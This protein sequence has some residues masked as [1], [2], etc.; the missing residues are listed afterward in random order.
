MDLP[1]QEIVGVELIADQNGDEVC[2]VECP[3]PMG[4]A[5]TDIVSYPLEFFAEMWPSTARD[6]IDRV[7]G[8]KL[9]E[10]G[11]ARGLSG[12]AGNVLIDG[13]HPASKTDSLGDILGRI[14][15]GQVARID[16]IRGGAP[17][18]D[19]QG[20]SVVA[21]VVRKGGDTLAGVMD[22]AS[23]IVPATD[24]K[25]IS[26]DANVTRRSGSSLFEGSVEFDLGDGGDHAFTDRQKGLD[27][28]VP[29]IKSRIAR[30]RENRELSVSAAYERPLLNGTVRVNGNFYD[31]HHSGTEFENFERP[32]PDQF[33]E[34]SDVNTPQGGEVGA[35]YSVALGEG[36]N[37]D[38]VFLHQ[39]RNKTE[40]VTS[41]NGGDNSVFTKDEATKETVA[42]LTMSMQ[43]L[44]N[45]SLE[46]GFEG[47]Y[48]VLKGKSSLL[49]NGV[50]VEVPGA[51]AIVEEARG[52]LSAVL[53]WQL[54]DTLSLQSALRYEASS[55][56]APL[57]KTNLQFA[58]PSLLLSWSPA[59]LTQIRL[60]AA[61]EVGQLNFND[62]LFSASLSTGIVTAGSGT[63]RPT[64]TKLAEITFE[65]RFWEEGVVTASARHEELNDVIDLAPV[66][67]DTGFYDARSN[68]GSA[69]RDVFEVS[70]TFPLGPVGI[71]GARIEFNGQH[72]RSAITDPATGEVRAL[73]G[74][75]PYRWDVAFKQDVNKWRMNYGV[76]YASGFSRIDFRS[77]GRE[78]RYT[79]PYITAFAEYQMT[80][81]LTVRAELLNLTG[82]NFTKIRDEHTGVRNISP[83]LYI[84]DRTDDSY[85]RIQ[86]SLS[87]AFN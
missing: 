25:R 85:R 7:P 19:M 29:T 11:G 87:K 83:L 78:Y 55:L 52:E 42:S 63:L 15:A 38:T 32:T 34:T 6:M 1:P 5:G 21:N 43:P 10:G 57:A 20:K 16:V 13:N 58:K 8:F 40:T 46:A 9:D 39:W 44:S 71:D 59:S 2:A 70:S 81:S 3:P 84:E 69:T 4:G 76:T 60:R 51:N 53:L 77:A 82:R 27:L 75:N 28:E 79:R 17:G 37:L 12:A 23:V 66:Y 61:K 86:I 64:Q 30:R 73:S 56:T 65:Q 80:Q 18:I 35:R 41:E 26:L 47:A 14:P 72:H 67:T 68:I 48:N 45:L 31:K 62:F 24:R 54:Q 36:K 33:R 22:L 49:V 74:Q 50:D